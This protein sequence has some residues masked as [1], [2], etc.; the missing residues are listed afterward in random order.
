MRP[1]P[2]RND[3]AGALKRSRRAIQ[4]RDPTGDIAAAR[5][6]RE[7]ERA[8]LSTVGYM[9]ISSLLSRHATDDQCAEMVRGMARWWEPT[10]GEGL[11][12]RQWRIS[13]HAAERA[14]EM[15]LTSDQVISILTDP[16]EIVM[17]DETSKYTG[18]FL[19][20]R[21]D[22]AAAVGESAPPRS[23]ITFLYRYQ[24]DYEAQYANPAA[25]REAR[26][27]SHL[28]RKAA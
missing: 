14:V 6:D 13:Q 17:Q 1:T 28:P 11:S 9:A 2:T 27:W 25:G 24:D 3:F 7:R 20:F 23:V 19:Y 4:Y 21:G 16:E 12:R 26:A 22:Y 5:V 8:E 18:E 10:G 15:R